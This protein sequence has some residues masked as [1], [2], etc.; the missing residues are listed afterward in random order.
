MN[1]ICFC[2]I[3]YSKNIYI[4]SNIVERPTSFRFFTVDKYK[5]KKGEKKELI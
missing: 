3:V 2:L 1:V 4:K 5:G